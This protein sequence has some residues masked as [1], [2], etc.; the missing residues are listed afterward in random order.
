MGKVALVI[1]IVGLGVI[2]KQAREYDELNSKYKLYTD[3]YNTL[4]ADLKQDCEN[5]LN[6]ERGFQ[7]QV[8]CYNTI[9]ALCMETK[10]PK[11][12]IEDNKFVCKDM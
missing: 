7:R 10:K 2:I 12:C 1:F 4:A 5:I 8:G 9:E 3:L 11:T 6:T